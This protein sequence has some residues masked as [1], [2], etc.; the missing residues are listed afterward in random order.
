MSRR[1]K[2]TKG[3]KKGT[4]VYRLTD[5]FT[6]RDT[7]P[8]HI[9]ICEEWDAFLASHRGEPI[10]SLV[11]QVNARAP[12]SVRSRIRALLA[13]LDGDDVGDS[14]F[15]ANMDRW[16]S[17]LNAQDVADFKR[18]FAAYCDKHGIYETI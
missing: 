12:W 5:V 1:R 14:Y 18:W 6:N 15:K 10:D 17:P 16:L 9:W 8:H 13:R 7:E 3:L 11:G 2:G 4:R